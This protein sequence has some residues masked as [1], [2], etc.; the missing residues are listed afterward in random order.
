MNLCIRITTHTFDEQSIHSLRGRE[1]RACSSEHDMPVHCSQQGM[2]NNGNKIQSKQWKRREKNVQ[3]TRAAKKASQLN[4]KLTP[5]VHNY[6]V[7]M[8]R[9]QLTA[10][11]VTLHLAFSVILLFLCVFIWNEKQAN[12]N[13]AAHIQSVPLKLNKLF[14]IF[15]TIFVPFASYPL[16]L[17]GTLI[18]LIK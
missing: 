3:S 9:Q 2:L 1:Q 15:V 8:I 16:E 4:M 13:N 14:V 11:W 5:L 18:R 7:E 10:N 12:D 17:E 6:W